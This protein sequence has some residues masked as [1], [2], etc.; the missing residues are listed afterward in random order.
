MN[1]KIGET[2]ETLAADFL[3]KQGLQLLERNWR[4]RFGEIDLVCRDGDSI[5]IVEVRLRSNIRFGS[6]A[7]SIDRRKQARLI[8]AASLYLARKPST[9]CRFDVVLM[10]DEQ[11]KDLEWIRN[12]FST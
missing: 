2:A 3:R 11:G 9:P 7:A 12:A 6:A 8:A 10:A 1:K 4:C 5:V